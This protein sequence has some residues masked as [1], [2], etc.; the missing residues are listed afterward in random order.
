MT[1]MGMV[2]KQSKESYLK[3]WCP[4]ILL[5]DNDKEFVMTQWSALVENQFKGY[6]CKEYGIAL[7]FTNPYT[8]DQKPQ[9]E[10]FV[11]KTMQHGINSFIKCYLH[12][13]VFLILPLVMFHIHCSPLEIHLVLVTN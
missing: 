4:E 12:T 2:T 9:L 11:K 1:L 8:L 6:V 13:G 3:T 5:S 10:N 7:H